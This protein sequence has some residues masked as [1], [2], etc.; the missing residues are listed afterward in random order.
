MAAVYDGKTVIAP[1]SPAVTAGGPAAGRYDS[2]HR[3]ADMPDPIDVRKVPIDGVT[4]A[5]GLARL[6]D[7]GVIAADRALPVSGKAEGNGGVNEYTRLL[8][9]RALREVLLAK[10]RRTAGEVGQ[11]PRGWSGGT[12]GVLS[13]HATIFA[14]LDPA[15]VPASD[16]A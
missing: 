13:P 7:D 10:G 12:D 16:E 5:S 2:G 6:I 1:H 15:T 3:G 4:D 9:A 8:A 14:T 11:V